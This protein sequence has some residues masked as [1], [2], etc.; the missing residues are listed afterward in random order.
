MVVAAVGA[1][2]RKI[3]ADLASALALGGDCLADFAVLRKQPDLAG[4]V[5]SAWRVDTRRRSSA[6]PRSGASPG[7]TYLVSS[8]FKQ[9]EAQELGVGPVE[10]IILGFPGNHFK[11][12]IVPALAKL[13]DS[14]TVRVIDLVFILKDGDGNV[15]T[16]EFDQL[17]E[18][19]PFSTLEGEV[20]GLINQE[21]IAYAADG[22][23]PNTSAAILVWEDTWATEFAEAVWS[24]GGIMLEGARIPAELIEAASADSAAGD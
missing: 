9:E 22:L 16:F 11:S 12:E 7:I 2:S 5:T 1:R 8:R 17:E 24:A 10:Y 18:L 6:S 15:T 14:G 21:D 23:E 3:V 19:A 20:S 4:P 13:I